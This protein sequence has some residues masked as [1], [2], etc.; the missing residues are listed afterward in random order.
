MQIFSSETGEWIQSTVS[1]PSGFSSD[2]VFLL[3]RSFTY[4]GMLYFVGDEA[5]DQNFL[6][7]M[8]PFIINDCNSAH[9]L[10][11]TNGGD[12]IGH[13]KCHFI[14]FHDDPYS[15]ILEYLG[16]FRG[17][18]LM[19][20]YIYYSS[21]FFV[22]EVNEEEMHGGAGKLCLEDMMKEYSVFTGHKNDSGLS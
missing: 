8:D 18:L 10:S 3:Q 5:G 11:S 1:I 19:G 12:I 6:M 17:R 14:Q 9:S 2:G 21:T 15:F 13:Y 20:S 4:N 7:G 22:R 16:E